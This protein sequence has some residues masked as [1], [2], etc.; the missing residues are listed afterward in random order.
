MKLELGSMNRTAVSLKRMSMGMTGPR[1][2]V[3]RDG[4]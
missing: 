4:A 2:V 3:S 1:A